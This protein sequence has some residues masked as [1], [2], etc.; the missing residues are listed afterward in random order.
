M[1][2]LGCTTA[3]PGPCS[4]LSLQLLSLYPTNHGFRNAQDPTLLNLDFNN[5]NRED[6]G[7]VKVDYQFNARHAF[8]GRYFIGDSVQ[9]EESQNVL[10]PYWLTEALTRAQVLGGTWNWSLSNNAVNQ[11]RFGFNRFSQQIYSDDHNKPA[12]DYGIN[13]G[14]TN[15]LD[16]GFP[17]ITVSSFN[18]LGGGTGWPLLT[19]P[20]LTYQISDNLS[21]TRGKHSIKFGGEFR[22][23]STD[24]TRDLYGKGSITFRSLE[25]F[26][27]GDYRKGA[28]FTGDSSRNVSQKSFGLYAQDNWRIVPRFTV[29]AGLR[30]DVSLPIT[31]ANGQLANF[32][33]TVGI[34]QVGQQ[35]RNRI[36]RTGIISLHDWASPGTCS[37]TARRFCVRASE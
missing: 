17:Q 25:D 26:L 18:R 3:V 34:E 31:E 20:N 33:P 13:T 15:P 36:T 9:N 23:G 5:T 4:P 12:T 21:W 27:V 8:S 28:I 6:N 10:Q 2:D 11:L 16:Y 37:A 1:N 35:I 30:Y 14:V 22:T 29:T 32:D 19:T 7:I 24:N